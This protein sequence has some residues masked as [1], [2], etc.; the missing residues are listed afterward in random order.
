MSTLA[1]IH[2]LGPSDALL[3]GNSIT[4]WHKIFDC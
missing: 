4:F 3:P 2:Q 1:K